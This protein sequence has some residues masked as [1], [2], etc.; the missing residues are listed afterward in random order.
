MRSLDS[1]L[2]IVPPIDRI[3]LVESRLRVI[4]GLLDKHRGIGGV[5]SPQDIALLSDE[6]GCCA[7]LLRS[8]RE[9]L[10]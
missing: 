4:G 5:V 10:A 6:L 3:T 8:V 9:N 7:D 1:A 2:A